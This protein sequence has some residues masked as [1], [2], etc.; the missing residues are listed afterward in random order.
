[1]GVGLRGIERLVGVELIDAEKEAVMLTGVLVKPAS[2]GRHRARP[3]KFWL[4]T[5]VAT[6]V[7]VRHVA[8]AEH[9]TADP[10]RI[11][12]CSPGITLMPPLVVPSREVRVVILTAGLEEMR[13]VRDQHGHSTSPPQ[14]RH[15]R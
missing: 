11:R 14:I 7:V 2:R 10:A 9:R 1:R 4:F 6:G 13:M 15:N 3:R 12:S 5:E 8:T